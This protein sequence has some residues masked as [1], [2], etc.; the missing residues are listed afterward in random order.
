MS[1]AIRIATSFVGSLRGAYRRVLTP[2]RSE[3]ARR[4]P[5]VAESEEDLYVEVGGAF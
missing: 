5:A 4:E 2:P 1:Q 3:A